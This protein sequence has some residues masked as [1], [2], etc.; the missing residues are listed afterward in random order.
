MWLDGVGL[1]GLRA[2][3]YEGSVLWEGGCQVLE[4]SLHHQGEGVAQDAQAPQFTP[5]YLNLYQFASIYLNF[6]STFLNLPKST[7]IYLNLP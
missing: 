4:H 5:V 6:P 3:D 2:K 1:L 7:S